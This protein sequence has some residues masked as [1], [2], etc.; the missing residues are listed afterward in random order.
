MEPTKINEGGAARPVYA[1]TIKRE[2]V[3]WL[4]LGRVPLSQ[5][6]IL[7]GVQGGGKS[8]LLQSMTAMITSGA[9]RWCDGATVPKRGKVLW[10]DSEN[11][12]GSAAI[13]NLAA[14]GAD[15]SRVAFMQRGDLP[16]TLSSD[17]DFATIE[18]VLE[19]GDFRMVVLDPIDDFLP[20]KVNGNDNGD[21]RAGLSKWVHRIARRYGVAVVGVKHVGKPPKEGGYRSALAQ[22]LGSTAW[23]AVPRSVLMMAPGVDP[24]L[25]VVSREKGNLGRKPRDLA[26]RIVESDGDGASIRWEELPDD[27][28]SM[29]VLMDAKRPEAMGQ[30]KAGLVFVLECLAD[31]P[32]PVNEIQ[33]R[34][35][36]AELSWE[37]TRKATE[38]KVYKTNAGGRWW[39]SLVE[40]REQCNLL[41]RTPIGQTV[42]V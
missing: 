22:V 30:G 39:W 34:V 32:R 42:G 9:S 28:P 24:D 37:S 33:A 25:R 31:G 19:A 21:T 12:P 6:T 18:R 27:H 35:K 41:A 40:H 20:G 3:E 36:L 1:N 8:L 17:E 2:R 11:D 29:D 16:M 38:G 26:F 14:M 10:F 5:L 4:W 15:L 13:P 23:T 7:A